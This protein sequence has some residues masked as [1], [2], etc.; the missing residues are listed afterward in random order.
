MKYTFI[1]VT[2]FLLISCEKDEGIDFNKN[3]LGS[4]YI[5]KEHSE[6]IKDSLFNIYQST[7]SAEFYDSGK[8]ILHEVINFPDTASWTYSENQ[9]LVILI[10][11]PNSQFPTHKKLRV[12]VTEI[13]YQ[14]WEFNS[15]YNINGNGEAVKVKEFWELTRKK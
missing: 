5:N 6:E 9:K 1:L 12:L 15:T 10:L 3:I 13:D 4:W 14:K 7:Y 2:A 11:R 8:V